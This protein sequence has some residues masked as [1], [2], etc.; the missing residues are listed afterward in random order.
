M[1]TNAK[2]EPIRIILSLNTSITRKNMILK[3]SVFELK[4]F[5]LNPWKY[6]FSKASETCHPPPKKKLQHVSTK[7]HSTVTLSSAEASSGLR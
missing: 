1:N 2:I 4:C 7:K 3:H 6:Q 5:S